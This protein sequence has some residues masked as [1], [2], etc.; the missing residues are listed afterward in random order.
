[1][2][3][4]LAVQGDRPCCFSFQSMKVTD[5]ADEEDIERYVL[6]GGCVSGLCVCVCVCVCVCAC[7]CVFV[8]VCLC[9]CVCFSDQV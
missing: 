1:M 6:G 7:M 4:Y 8:S 2:G 9:Q 3:V 5:Q